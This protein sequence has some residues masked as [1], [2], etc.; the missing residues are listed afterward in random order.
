[1]SFIKGKG[2]GKCFTTVYKGKH[3]FIV[4]VLI[5]S[6]K[7]KIDNLDHSLLILIEQQQQILPQYL[8][9]ASRAYFR[10]L[11]H[12]APAHSGIFICFC[13]F[14]TPKTFNLHPVW[15]VSAPNCPKCT[16]ICPFLFVLHACLAFLR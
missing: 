15:K 2:L 7:S 16:K 8:K 12:A 3:G 10:H 4:L 6:R 14:Y 9:I 13:H 5:K 1:M 11:L